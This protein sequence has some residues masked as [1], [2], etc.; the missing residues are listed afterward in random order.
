M[1]HSNHV[2]LRPDELNES[3]LQGAPIY[4]RDDEKISSIDHV[5]GTGEKAQV[6]FDVGGFLGIGAKRVSVQAGQLD[7]MRDEE[8]NVHAVTQMTEDQLKALPEHVETTM[9]GD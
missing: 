1:D 3:V 8:G 7:V 9:L 2:R 6:V 4:G 5:Q